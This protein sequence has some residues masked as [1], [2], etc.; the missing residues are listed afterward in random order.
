[1]TQDKYSFLANKNKKLRPSFGE[2][3]TEIL[4]VNDNAVLVVAD[5]A[6]A[7][8]LTITDE[9][10][11]KVIDCGIAEQNMI[12]VAAGLA[13]AGKKPFVFAFSPFASER[14][15]EQIKLDLA[16]ADLGVVIIGGDAGIGMGTQGVTHYGWEDM[17]IMRSLPNMTVLCPA[18]HV[19]MVKCL[20]IGLTYKHPLYIRL[21]GGIPINVTLDNCPLEFGKANVLKDGTDVCFIGIGTVMSKVFT[22]AEML[23][24]SNIS[25]AVV[26]MCSVKPYDRELLEHYACSS[27][28]IITIEE[29]SIVNGLGSAVACFLAEHGF[30]GKFKIVGLPDEYPHAVSPY[31]IMSVEYNFTPEYFAETAAKML[32]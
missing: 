6:K 26:N 13:R 7:C 24:K 2:E 9:I 4:K 16:Y 23:E 32:E 30:N 20:E 19:E 18:D 3:I 27:K 8:R 29:H 15:F 1:M 21:T 22:A 14:C 28:V 10:K 31:G 11:D 25:T 17:G 5:S 12:S